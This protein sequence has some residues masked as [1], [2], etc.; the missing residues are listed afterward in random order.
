MVGYAA[1]TRRLLLLIINNE[2][3][4]RR[5]RRRRGGGESN[6]HPTTRRWNKPTPHQLI[7]VYSIP[8]LL[9]LGSVDGH[10]VD[11]LTFVSQ[12]FP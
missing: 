2:E 7:K 5:R 6:Y 11:G 10:G 8:L 9:L 4:R 1:T 3:R 12:R